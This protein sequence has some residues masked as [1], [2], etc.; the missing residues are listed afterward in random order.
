MWG[1]ANS[2]SG[3]PESLLNSSLQLKELGEKKEI[4]EFTNG[5]FVTEEGF[6]HKMGIV[7][8]GL[9][10]ADAYFCANYGQGTMVLVIKSDQIP[11]VDYNRMEKVLT[12][13]PKVISGIELNHKA[14]FTNYLIDRQLGINATE[15]TITGTRNGK[16]VTAEFDELARLINLSGEL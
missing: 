7:T 1:W 5:H 16:I 15:N 6:E 9:L 2:Q 12:T 13:F 3:F 14:A 8:C 11:K 4:E 10:K